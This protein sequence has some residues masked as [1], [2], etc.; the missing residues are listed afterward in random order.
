MAGT[1][2]RIAHPVSSAR[3]ER[4][5]SSNRRSQG[6]PSGRH[7]HAADA[8]DEDDEPTTP[9][10]RIR[11]HSELHHSATPK[12]HRRTRSNTFKAR[13]DRDSI[14]ATPAP[15]R[16]RVRPSLAGPFLQETTV[17]ERARIT[18]SL[19]KGCIINFL[20]AGL[21]GDVAKHGVSQH[22]RTAWDSLQG[23]LCLYEG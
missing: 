15:K 14:L 4:R 3:H 7:H 10:Q 8:D 12:S 17:A 23:M 2:S 6:R 9:K 16:L 1:R 20:R 18:S 22:C 19:A 5:L 11:A 21:T 13:P